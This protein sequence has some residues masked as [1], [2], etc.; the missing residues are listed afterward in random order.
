MKWHAISQSILGFPAL[1]M[2]N[3]EKKYATNFHKIDLGKNAKI[4]RSQKCEIYRNAYEIFRIFSFFFV[5]RFPHL[6]GNPS[7]FQKP[8]R[9]CLIQKWN[10]FNQFLQI[11]I[12]DSVIVNLNNVQKAELAYYLY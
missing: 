10:C 5:K 12:C 7:P 11:L 2:R 8:L 9:L 6:A 4:L 3:F 1:T